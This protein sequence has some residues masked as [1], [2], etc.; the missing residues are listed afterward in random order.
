MRPL[1]PHRDNL[2]EGSGQHGIVRRVY[3]TIKFSRVAS[4]MAVSGGASSRHDM[5]SPAAST[6]FHVRR[7]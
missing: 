3:T 1:V 6:Q 2:L 7:V 5:N 4:L